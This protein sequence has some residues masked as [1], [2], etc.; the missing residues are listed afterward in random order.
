MA[1]LYTEF[2]VL[3][4]YDVKNVCGGIDEISLFRDDKFSQKTLLASI[5]DFE[6]DTQIFLLPIELGGTTNALISQFSF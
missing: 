5:L 4:P 1:L 3:F 6:Q 2:K